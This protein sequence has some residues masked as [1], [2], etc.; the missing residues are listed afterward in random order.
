MPRCSGAATR[1]PRRRSTTSAGSRRQAPR[2]GTLDVPRTLPQAL[3]FLLG[4]WIALWLSPLVVRA[5]PGG[6]EDPRLA[7]LEASLYQG[8][9]AER[10]RQHLI[11]LERR[12][13][14][15]AVA[16]GHS[17]DMVRRHYLAHES[18]EGW[19][20]VDRLDHAHIDGFTLAGENIGITDRAD[21]NREIL[22][23]WIQSPVHR[24]NLFAPPFNATG[25]GIARAPNGS[26]VY[27]QVFVTYPR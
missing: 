27:T 7:A 18:P 24:D 6:A 4:F 26:L 17:L 23:A 21:A 1:R 10:A 12:P 15:D 16:R 3:G 19:N 14:L 13:D 2:S 20:A 8:V 9:N 22:Q 5:E 11:P 25:I